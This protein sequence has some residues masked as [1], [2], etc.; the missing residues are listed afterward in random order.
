MATVHLTKKHHMKKTLVRR[1]VQ[2]LADKLAEE[3]SADYVWEKDRLVFKR[4]GA[5]GFV[6][7]GEGELEVQV[8]LNPLLSPLKGKIEETVSTYL[9]ERLA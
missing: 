6:R 5:K 8:K 3:L 7:L 4:T 9:D 1:E 2:D